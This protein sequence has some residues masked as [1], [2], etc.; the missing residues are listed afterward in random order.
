MIIVKIASRGVDPISHERDS[1]AYWLAKKWGR[2]V[3]AHSQPSDALLVNSDPQLL[4]QEP[5]SFVSRVL[6]GCFNIGE[7]QRSVRMQALL[8]PD[9]RVKRVA[10]YATDYCFTAFEALSASNLAGL[11]GREEEKRPEEIN[12]TSS[13]VLRDLEVMLYEEDEPD[14]RHSL[15][16]HAYDIACQVIKDAYTHY[17]GSAPIPTIAPD[18]DGGVRIE[19]Q[20]NRR[21]V[22]LIVPDSDNEESYVYSKGGGPSDID[23]P[24]SGLAL[25]RRLLTI[26][27]D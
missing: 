1:E 6:E 18:G 4:G 2:V 12:Q 16:R 13:N 20:S 21:V 17:I 8:T 10:K 19:W 22:R 24:A 14:F 26:F 11:W 3:F 25:A 9:R 5:E 7:P 27:S 23:E 15:T